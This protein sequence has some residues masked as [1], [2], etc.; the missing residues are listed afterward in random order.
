MQLSFGVPSLPNVLIQLLVAV[1]RKENET[2]DRRKDTVW[3]CNESRVHCLRT[4]KPQM[5]V[6]A[7]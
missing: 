1:I 5:E 2:G 6:G 3:C 4:E 7:I